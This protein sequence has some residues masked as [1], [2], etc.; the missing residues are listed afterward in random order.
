MM[1]ELCCDWEGCQ[2][3]AVPGHFIHEK[4]YCPT[5]T[6]ALIGIDPLILME[7][8]PGKLTSRCTDTGKAT[9]LKK[10]AVG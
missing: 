6:L 9:M 8:N 2:N 3:K 1:K 4:V 10:Q 5:H 7:I